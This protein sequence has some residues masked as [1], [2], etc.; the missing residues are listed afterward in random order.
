MSTSVF[1]VTSG[2][3]SLSLAS[4]KSIVA[5][6]TETNPDIAP[7]N[8]S[9]KPLVGFESCLLCKIKVDT[10]GLADLKTRTVSLELNFAAL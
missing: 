5:P 6:V 1:E 8:T 3:L 10:A 4:R 2:V 9:K 7:T